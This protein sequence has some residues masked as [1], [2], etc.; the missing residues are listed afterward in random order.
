MMI[1]ICHQRKNLFCHVLALTLLVAQPA[2]AFEEVSSDELKDLAGK[3]VASENS[4]KS[5]KSSETPDATKVEGPAP[6]TTEKT[7]SEF[8]TTKL[9]EPITLTET[10]PANHEANKT[11]DL[12]PLYLSTAIQMNSFRD[13]RS[14]ASF[15]QSI[16]LRDAINYVL[17][18]GMQIKLSRE[19]LIYQHWATM[20]HV[21]SALPSFTMQYN[22][23]A[24]NVYNLD[25]TSIS[26][27]FFAG[28]FMPVFA[29]GSVVSNI[30]SQY[31]RE[32][33]WRN[34]YRSTFQ[35]VFLTV[36]Q[37]YTNLL[38]QRVLLQIWAKSVEA[39][40]ELVRVSNLQLQ[41]GTGTKFA[42]LQAQAQLAKDK[43]SFLS[44]QVQ[45]RLAAL[46]L[47]ATLNYPMDVNLIPVEETLTEAAIFSDST[48]LR[49][50][51]KDAMDHHPGLRQ[52][53]YFRL[54]A[55]R[56]MQLVASSY[57]PAVNFF[58]GYMASNTS[59]NPPQ[60]AGALGG[61]ATTSITSFLNSTFAGR[62]SN[63]ALGQ[64]QG[65]S[66][67]AGA[68]ATQGAN[69]APVALPASSGGVPL[70]ALQSGSAVSSGAVAPSILGGGS[71]T[72]SSGPNQ[73][74][75]FQAPAGIFPGVFRQVQMGF[76]LNWSL[77]NGGMSTAAQLLQAK[78]LSRQAMMQCNQ[79][80]SLVEQN[81]RTDYH[82][83]KSAKQVIDKAA[84]AVTASREALRLARIR[85][86]AGV[87]TSL[88]VI[89]AQ[90]DY[91]TNLTS[92]AQAIVASNVAQAQL[93]HDIG[94][95]NATTLTT[96]YKP[97]VYNEPTPSKKI[98]WFYP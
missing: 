70:Y 81:V 10:T 96:G 93:L 34:T 87:G 73:N 83:I 7:K 29:G 90:K 19:S 61:V 30:L 58:I 24:A 15:D 37:N 20:A 89:T 23:R 63:N 48:N 42:V 25:T 46:A 4:D 11:L 76:Q 43:Q 52:Y 21:A 79:E 26:R 36:Y 78:S 86:N 51:L 84:A 98:N 82:N 38:L 66:P 80:L 39:D 9:V 92:K 53:E 94:M 64:Q 17:D 75:S 14:E 50:L 40:Q 6:L 31:Y 45:M 5:E 47:N 49:M 74:G 18:Q 56:Y 1:G 16:R 88:E 2:M 57:Y 35:D 77:P 67:T 85:L 62:V 54:V 69:T 8:E 60:N 33:A 97:G 22:L 59:V 95:I 28:V 55:R 91:I 65:F 41:N 3:L 27:Q 72:T 13:I 32:K 44:Q 68:T 71:G 12:N